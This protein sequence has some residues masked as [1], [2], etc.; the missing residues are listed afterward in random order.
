V[1]LC[2]WKRACARAEVLE[3]KL[4]GAQGWAAHALG[5]QPEEPGLEPE[6]SQGSL[7][8][9][10]SPHMKGDLWVVWRMGK[11]RRRGQ[12]GRCS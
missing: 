8:N 12:A 7:E 1:V 5:C 2:F 4:E 10:G 3:M 6:V 9:A 11:P